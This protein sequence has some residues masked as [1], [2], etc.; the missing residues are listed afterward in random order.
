MNSNRRWFLN[1]GAKY[2]LALTL[3]SHTRFADAQAPS[4]DCSQDPNLD[5]F[6]LPISVDVHTHIFNGRDIPIAAF[7]TKIVAPEHANGN[8][9][10]QFALKLERMVYKLAPT[11]DKEIARLNDFLEIQKRTGRTLEDMLSEDAAAAD[12]AY[13]EELARE[14]SVDEKFRNDYFKDLQTRIEELKKLGGRLEAAQKL[15]NEIRALGNVGTLSEKDTVQLQ[16]IEAQL[17]GLQLL[18]WG[19][20]FTRFRSLNARQLLSSFRV[21]NVAVL[22]NS[23]N[24]ALGAVDLFLPALVDFDYWLGEGDTG[25]STPMDKQIEIME[26]IVRLSS[27]RIHPLIA[28]DPLRDIKKSGE[29]LRLVMAAAEKGFVG[30]KIYPPMGFAPFGNV[31]RNEPPQWSDGDFKKFAAELDDS[32]IRLF[33]FCQDKGFPVLAHAN[34]TNGPSREFEDLAGPIYWEL[35]LA[36]F[37]QLRVCFGHFGGEDGFARKSPSLEWQKGF[38]ALMNKY[39]YTFADTAYFAGILGADSGKQIADSLR[40]MFKNGGDKIA[41]RMLYGSDW[42]M[43]A[44]E[45]G[46]GRYYERFRK[47]IK[48]I[49]G[50]NGKL[51]ERFFGKNAL[52]FLGLAPLDLNYKRMETYYRRGKLPKPKWFLDISKSGR[53]VGR[54]SS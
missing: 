16:Q 47:V 32:M 8:L 20:K 39:E 34:R 38:I 15:G 27:G 18:N 35:A 51:S 26:R 23:S 29:S 31:T 44:R 2:G 46:W 12:K 21:F 14:L 40:V 53:S 30:V 5:A 17:A 28:F 10:Q 9:T 1:R 50:P 3:G 11:A 25:K 6:R 19:R 36:K 42:L 37:P 41:S 52:I 49:E 13:A 4:R 45:Q 54:K 43:L 48:E 24:C 7:L 33:S 22:A